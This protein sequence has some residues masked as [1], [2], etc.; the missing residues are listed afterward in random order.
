MS[1]PGAFGDENSL[2]TGCHPGAIRCPPFGTPAPPPRDVACAEFGGSRAVRCPSAS[3]PRQH[4][5]PMGLT[6]SRPES[7][8]KR[9]QGSKDSINWP[10]LVDDKCPCC[11]LQRQLEEDKP[12][13]CPKCMPFL[14]RRLSPFTR[15]PAN[16]SP[17]I[18]SFPLLVSTGEAPAN[19]KQDWSYQV[20][21]PVMLEP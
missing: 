2:V 5:P 20:W 3:P 8:K 21:D 7:A 17:Q 1:R 19:K 14:N 16:E 15:F 18:D 12:S 9:R 6:E 4:G 10:S 13:W 11:C